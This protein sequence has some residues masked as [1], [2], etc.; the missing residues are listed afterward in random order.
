[1][2]VNIITSTGP[3]PQVDMPISRTTHSLMNALSSLKAS[4]LQHLSLLTG[5]PLIGTKPLLAQRIV[6]AISTSPTFTSRDSWRRESWEHE[7]P[8]LGGN[9]APQAPKSI[10]SIDM[11]IRNLAFA[12]LVVPPRVENEYSY[13]SGLASPILNAWSR[14]EVSS[15]PLGSDPSLQKSAPQVSGKKGTAEKENGEKDSNIGDE[16]Y[17]STDAAALKESFAPEIYAVHAY[18]LI[19]SLIGKYKPTHILI[20][21]Q[22]FRTGGKAPVLEWTLRVGMFEAMLFSVIHTLKQERNIA[23]EASSVDPR[24]VV[25]YWTF[26]EHLDT[27]K[28]QSKSVN[29]SKAV[30]DIKVQLV[31]KW[32]A[33]IRTSD[34]RLAR[35]RQGGFIGLRIDKHQVAVTELVDKYLSS[36]LRRNLI[37][38]SKLEHMLS[39]AGASA[40]NR[41]KKLDDL[42]DCLLQGLA[43]LEWYNMREGIAHDG[44]EYALPRLNDGQKQGIKPT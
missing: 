22:R 28:N 27:G 33:A 25:A 4:E 1:M 14:V 40:T 2:V 16:N 7:E 38:S 21:K 12:H 37:K 44:L 36:C 29:N 8:E 35:M 31:G 26:K 15:L 6:D 17:S 20:E 43:W 13:S 19:T 18:S 3:L 39:S 34:S 24:R 9:N 10:L 23:I 30:K 11:G 5:L 32:L 42:A 41:I